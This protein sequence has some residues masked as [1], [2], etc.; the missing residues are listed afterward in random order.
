ME[1]CRMVAEVNGESVALTQCE[2]NGGWLTPEGKL[3]WRDDR[4]GQWWLF[5]Q[6]D[7]EIRFTPM[8]VELSSK[9][10]A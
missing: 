5:S 4:D 3:L 2:E 6:K 1:S 9:R 7:E 8:S 10:Q